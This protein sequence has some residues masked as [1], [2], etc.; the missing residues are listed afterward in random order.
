M[1]RGKI[2]SEAW[3]G[4]NLKFT[5]RRF[6]DSKLMTMWLELT[7]FASSIQ[8]NDE[9]GAMI[10]KFNSSGKYSAQSQYAMVNDR[11]GGVG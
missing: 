11:G 6:V 2:V 4:I 5:C 7:Q 10:W 3:D 9:E 8:L 1:N